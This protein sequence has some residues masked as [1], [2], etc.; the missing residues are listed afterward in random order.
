M[1][2]LHY[3]ARPARRQQ[4][5][6]ALGDGTRGAALAAGRSSSTSDEPEAP[7]GGPIRRNLSSAL[8]QKVEVEGVRGPGEEN[9]NGGA[10]GASGSG[11]GS[12]NGHIHGNGIANGNGGANGNGN[13]VCGASAAGAAAAAEGTPAPAARPLKGLFRPRGKQHGSDDA[14]RVGFLEMGL[15]SP[16]GSPSPGQLPRTEVQA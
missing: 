14:P 6:P 16:P 7:A 13:G 12:G 1:D 10:E 4:Y 3:P 15:S 9:G 5:L 8:L 2:D 11:S